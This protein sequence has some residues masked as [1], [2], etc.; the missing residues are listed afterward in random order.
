MFK[1]AVGI[2]LL[3][4]YQ[5]PWRT[6]EYVL[7]EEN[8]ERLPSE[9]ASKL[10]TRCSDNLSYIPDTLNQHVD[11]VKY[12]RI[13]IHFLN[14]KSGSSNYSGTTGIKYAKD[15]VYYANRKLVY[16]KK[17]NLPEGNSTPVYNPNYQ[18]VITPATD[19]PSDQ[20]IY[21]H[22]DDELCYYVNEGKRNNYNRSVI[23]KYAIG[24]DSILNVFY[25]VHHPDS[26]KSKTYSASASGIAL[27]KSLKMGTTYNPSDKPWL[28]A[29]LLNHEVGHVM[30]LSHTWNQNDGCDD[31]PKNAN[32]WNKTKRAPCNGV[33]SNNMMDYNSNQH[34]ISPCQIGK[35]RKNMAK[36]KSRQRDL[37]EE[38]W[39]KLDGSKTVYISRDTEFRG[40]K[41]LQGNLHILSGAKLTISCRLSMPAGSEIVVYPGSSLVLNKA[42]IHN[43]CDLGWQGIRVLKQ[44]K[45]EGRVFYNG[46]CSI[47]NTDADFQTNPNS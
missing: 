34:A 13:N 45:K 2:F 17:M 32:C 8:I 18:Y 36:L 19:D 39:C 20:G 38:R 26:V 1:Y 9:N 11:P 6:V 43:S 28:Y 37:L 35:V 12:I 30:G 44:G 5:C 16:N 25:M 21:F 15:L 42:K 4:M 23:N 22:I 33:I 31:T 46:S 29:S 47:E 10:A 24:E 14:D 27:G 3:L 41:D 40:A 7:N